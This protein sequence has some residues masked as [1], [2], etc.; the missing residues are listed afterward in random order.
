[1]STPALT[2][3]AAHLCALIALCNSPGC[4][5]EKLGGLITRPLQG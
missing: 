4:S 1:M 2:A 5:L 3:P